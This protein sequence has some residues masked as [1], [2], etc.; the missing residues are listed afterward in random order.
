[1][2]SENILF[3]NN[4]FPKVRGTVYWAASPAYDAA[5]A[6]K[7]SPYTLFTGEL[8][9]VFENRIEGAG[10]VLKTDQIFAAIAQ[11]IADEE[12]KHPHPLPVPQQKLGAEGAQSNWS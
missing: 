12:K 8:V 11:R 3:R 1:M 10:S 9:G 7:K 5:L 4:D 2:G 6:N